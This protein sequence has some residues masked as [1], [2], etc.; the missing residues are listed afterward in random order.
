MATIQ[1]KLPTILLVPL[2]LATL[3]WA[4]T[5]PAYQVEIK[6]GAAVAQEILLPIDPQIRINAQHSNSI[7]FGLTMDGVRITCSPQ[8]SIW[9]A[10]MVDGSIHNP[11][12]SNSPV[13]MQTLPKGPTGKDRR[14][15]LAKWKI[16]QLEYTQ[17]VEVVASKP[18]VAA[19]NAKRRMDTC[20]MSYLVENKGK[21]AH[22]VAFRSSVDILINN[23]DG[24]LYASPTT[25]PGKVLNGVVLEGKSLPAFVQVLERPDVRDPGHVAVMTLKFGGK[26]E[27]PSK[28][29]LTQLGA[30]GGGNWDVPA[31][32]AGDSACAIYW[33][34]KTLKPGEKREMVWA[35][36]G[37][38][39]TNPENDGKVTVA[40]G[41]NLEPG[42]LFTVSA[43]VEDPVMSQ[44]LAIELP[45][46]IDRVEGAETQPVPEPSGGGY[47]LVLWKGRVT[48]AGA[49][50]I[51]VRSST[52]STQ[53]KSVLV[54]PIARQ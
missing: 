11:A 6:D 15:F 28:V 37:G 30:V 50:D 18:V 20:R 21:Q 7:Y 26:V 4:G 27:G 23:N 34:K 9:P 48:R 29:V 42:K 13:Q 25:E 14:G 53:T 44:T 35:Y 1:R 16:G 39:A 45:P 12:N 19:A 2:L 41:G 33:E 10:T 8:G 46:G 24:A 36:G 43:L 54:R 52:G 32:P 22:E 17:V 40:L 3:T 51:R 31:M 49:F 38:I 47:S 5:P